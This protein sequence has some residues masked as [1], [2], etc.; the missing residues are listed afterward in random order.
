MT[1]EIEDEAEPQVRRQER[2]QGGCEGRRR[3]QPAIRG[4]SSALPGA[5][6]AAGR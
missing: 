5:A 2:R 3:S 1:I 4:E 6:G